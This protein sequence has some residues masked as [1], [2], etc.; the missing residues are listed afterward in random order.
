MSEI[1][2]WERQRREVNA[3]NLFYSCLTA[4][5]SPNLTTEGWCLPVMFAILKIAE[6]I[7]K[8]VQTSYFMMEIYVYL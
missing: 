4:R 3:Y 5:A 7:S 8:Q 2:E 6:V 1:S